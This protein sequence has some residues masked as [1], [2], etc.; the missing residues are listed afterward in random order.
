MWPFTPVLCFRC[1]R[2]QAP[3]EL[4]MRRGTLRRNI[5]FHLDTQGMELSRRRQKMCLSTL[6]TLARLR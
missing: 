2:R 3:Q 6:G 1:P 5:M 4:P